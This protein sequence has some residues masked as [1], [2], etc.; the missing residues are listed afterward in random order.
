MSL[1]SITIPIFSLLFLTFSATSMAEKI[2]SGNWDGLRKMMT[3]EEFEKTGL[4][5]LSAD[6]LKLLDRWFLKF[7]AHD[8]QQMVKSD[9]KI[10]KLQNQGVKRHIVGHFSGWTGKTVFRLD[11]GEIWKQRLSS[12]Y[13]VSLENP[14]VEIKK[15]LF[16]F[17][18]MTILK[19]GRRV[20]VSRLK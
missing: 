5:N 19:T 11:N 10:Q 18:E 7:L 8:S 3:A 6:E 20:G 12:R 9:K 1:K 16:G 13:A 17:Y 15:N 4:D 2:K 14:A